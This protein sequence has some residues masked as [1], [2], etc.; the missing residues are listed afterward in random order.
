MA[1]PDDYIADARAA[2][3]V[4]TTQQSLLRRATS[5]AYYALF[6]ELVDSVGNILAPH[7]PSGLRTLVG[8]KLA[9]EQMKKACAQ[10]NGGGNPWTTA[11]AMAAPPQSLKDVAAAFVEL[12][13]LRHEADYDLDAA[14][15]SVTVQANIER[16]ENA[17]TRWRQIKTSNPDHAS[18]V[19]VSLMHTSPR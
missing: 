5:T 1:L 13:Q 10:W 12:Q 6:L 7:A 17:I 4:S 18:V 16:A 14:F 15:S 19:M 11:L 8:R 2:A 3:S 9:H